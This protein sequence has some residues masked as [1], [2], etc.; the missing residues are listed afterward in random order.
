MN[1]GNDPKE[2]MLTINSKEY[3]EGNTLQAS[4]NERHKTKY[5][6]F[7]LL[8]VISFGSHSK[9]DPKKIN[10]CYND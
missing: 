4:Q 7:P 5:P 2:R 3:S 10:N 8:F 9:Q 1:P 6:F